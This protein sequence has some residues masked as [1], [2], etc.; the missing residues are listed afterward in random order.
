MK[1][2]I[3][4]ILNS[5]ADSPTPILK[6]DP[7]LHTKI[8]AISKD[9]SFKENQVKWI[10]NWSMASLVTSCAIIFGIFLGIGL[11]EEES[12]SPDLISEYSNVIYQSD[13]IENFDSVLEKEEVEK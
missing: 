12:I 9:N 11:F 8:A 2:N 13:Y 6:A 7:F 1:N 10:L 4:K 3:D 5:K